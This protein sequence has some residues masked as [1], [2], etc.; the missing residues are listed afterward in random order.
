M[1]LVTAS[2]F[3]FFV[4]N[5]FWYLEH[6]R[7]MELGDSGINAL[8]VESPSPQTVQ[9]ILNYGYPP[10][11]D[12]PTTATVPLAGPYPANFG[13][14]PTQISYLADIKTALVNYIDY[15]LT[16]NVRGVNFSG[17][18]IIPPVGNTVI[19]SGK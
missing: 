6:Q 18:Y 2:D 12:V 3:Q 16:R 7:G 11:T 17:T 4:N 19:S 9:D 8:G 14:S 10:V 13:L 5:L 15:K 1:A